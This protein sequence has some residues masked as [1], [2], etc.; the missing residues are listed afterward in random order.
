[1]SKEVIYGYFRIEEATDELTYA[2]Y[3]VLPKLFHLAA[4]CIGGRRQVGYR[5]FFGPGLYLAHEPADTLGGQFA[6][7]WKLALADQLLDGR[8]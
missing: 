5:P 6:R 7:R 8:G 4:A 1:M 3:W 2:S